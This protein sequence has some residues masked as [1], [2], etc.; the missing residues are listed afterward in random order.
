MITIPYDIDQFDDIQQNGAVV[1]IAPCKFDS[2]TILIYLRNTNFDK[3]QLYFDNCEYNKK[4]DLLK[5]YLTTDI[6]YDVK[7]LNDAVIDVLNYKLIKHQSA[8][9]FTDDQCIQF[10]NDNQELID[11]IIKFF[12][13]LTVYLFIRNTEL[14]DNIVLDFDSINNEQFSKNVY[15][16]IEQSRFDDLYLNC[17]N[18]I[19]VPLD[20][21]NH[22]KDDNNDLFAILVRSF[23]PAIELFGMQQDSEKWKEIIDEKI[24]SKLRNLVV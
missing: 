20:F 1:D 17:V 18:S 19:D 24:D 9:Y 4:A 15:G 11:Q 21:I 10:I 14:S 8:E 7:L 2:R 16:I 13:S 5:C 3:V 6:I 22:F 23:K 12:G